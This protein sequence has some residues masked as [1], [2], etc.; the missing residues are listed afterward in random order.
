M[1]PDIPTTPAEVL[2]EAASVAAQLSVDASVT[3]QHV[4][5]TAAD[6]AKNDKER[7]ANDKNEM[8]DVLVAALNQVFGEKEEQQQFIN[9][10][11]VPMICKQISSIH[12][13]I[14]DIMLALESLK[15]VKSVVYAACGL[16]GV[17][18]FGALL[19]LIIKK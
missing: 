11:R 2:A 15:I 10:S 8:K 7:Q 14:A 12:E 9:V 5:E 6:V 17:S 3:A 16:I 1:S 19:A 13:N 4:L 18:V